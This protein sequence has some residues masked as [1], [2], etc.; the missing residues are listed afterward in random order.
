M[1]A[2]AAIFLTSPFVLYQVWSFV[3]PGLYRREE[4]STRCRSFSV[5]RRS[6]SSVV[7]SPTTSPFRWRSSF[8]LG[9]GEQFEPVI[10]IERYFGF[11]MSVILGLGLMFEL[12][13][14]ILLLA[15]MGVVTP[16]F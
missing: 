1:A 3:A 9:I 8:L 6:S 13:I 15:K 4:A 11:L 10:T 16:D 14:V 2:L 7:C 5:A 12:P